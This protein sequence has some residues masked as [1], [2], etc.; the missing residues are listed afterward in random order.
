MHQ[1]NVSKVILNSVCLGGDITRNPIRV[2]VLIYV[3]DSS[4]NVNIPRFAYQLLSDGY[5][6]QM[7]SNKDETTKEWFH[8]F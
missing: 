7:I 5:A 3:Y 6:L 1:K 2:S 8:G 4:Y